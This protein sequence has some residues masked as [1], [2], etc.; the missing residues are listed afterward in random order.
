MR[1][2]NTILEARVPSM[3]HIYA[4][5]WSLFSD[6]CSV[7]NKDPSSCEVS[8]ILTF[9]RELLDK[10]HNSSMLRVYVGAIAVN[11]TLVAGQSVSNNDLNVKFGD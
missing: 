6:L 7:Q 8:S 1:V 4:I 5:M 2:T 3:R 9:L 11:H 10:G